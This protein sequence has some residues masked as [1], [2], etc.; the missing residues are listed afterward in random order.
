MM[1]VILE[2]INKSN[3]AMQDLQDKVDSLKNENNSNHQAVN[4]K[5]ETIQAENA[6][7]REEL[8]TRINDRSRL[9]SRASSRATS[10]RQLAA[11]LQSLHEKMPDLEM[12]LET[13]RVEYSE[14]QVSM[15][16]IFANKKAADD[17]EEVNRLRD[18][19]KPAVSQRDNTISR[20]ETFAAINRPGNPVMKETFTRTTPENRAH[21][22]SPLTLEKCL[23]FCANLYV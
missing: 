8:L 18:R 10:P 5:F 20:R 9:S 16:E 7:T 19:R 23:T 21:L 22:S 15:T 3:N 14:P 13:P 4:D 12:P 1:T 11:R 2:A 17:F 6:A